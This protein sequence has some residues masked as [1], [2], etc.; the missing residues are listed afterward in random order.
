MSSEDS[1]STPSEI[2]LFQAIMQRLVQDAR[3]PRPT[4]PAG[5]RQGSTPT[6]NDQIAAVESLVG[7][8]VEEWADLI[9]IDASRLRAKLLRE[10]GLLTDLEPLPTPTG[11]RPRDAS[12]DN[13]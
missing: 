1:E 11:D 4:P 3:H 6:I 13:R 2:L 8:A 12:A 10:A 9:N 7:D 5:K